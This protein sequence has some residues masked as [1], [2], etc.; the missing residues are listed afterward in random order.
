MIRSPMPRISKAK[1]KPKLSS[2]KVKFNPNAGI[3]ST[4]A[5]TTSPSKMV[6]RFVSNPI[7]AA[8][9]TV[10]VTPAQAERPAEFI[11]P[12]NRAPKKGNA[13]IK[14]RDT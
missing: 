14:K 10:N 8:R 3:H 1:K 9:E 6:G 11:K 5:I 13:T 12:G 2:I 4:R 7:K